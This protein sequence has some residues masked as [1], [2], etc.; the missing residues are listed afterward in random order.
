MN[1]ITV[2]LVLVGLINF[3]PVMGLLGVTKLNQAYDVSLVSNDLVL[4]MRHRALLFGILGA[5]I[6][7]AAFT[8]KYQTAAMVMGFVSMAGYIVLMLTGSDYNAALTKIMWVD[9]VGIILVLIAAAL[10]WRTSLV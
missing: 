8:P 7:Y 5:F 6:L 9:V 10:K 3:A 2:C 4:L 1:A